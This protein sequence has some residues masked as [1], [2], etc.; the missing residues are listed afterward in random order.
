M[1]RFLTLFLAAFMVFGAFTRAK[2]DEGMWLPLLLNDYNYEE[3]KRLGLKLTPEQIYSINNSSVKDAI[4]SLGGFC[5]AEIVSKE[6]LLFT[7]HHCAYDAIQEHSTVEHNYLKDGFWATSKDKELHVP[8]LTVTFLVKVEDVTERILKI[9][10]G[11]DDDKDRLMQQEMELIKAEATAGTNYRAELKSMFDGNGYY[12]FLYETFNDIRLVGAPPSSIGKFGGDT[13]NWMWPRHTGD[14]SILRVYANQENE[15][16]EFSLDNKPYTP[17][18][19]L[20]VSL[21]GVKDGDFTM[22]MGYPGSTDRYFTSYEVTEQQ[23]VLAPAVIKI[24]G[25][26]LRIM[27]EEMDKDEAVQIKLASNYASLNNTY[28]YFKGNLN[29]LNKF[30][31]AS[32]K[33][34]EEK[35]FEAWVEADKKRQDEYSGVLK[36]IGDLVGGHAEAAEMNFLMNFAGFAPSAVNKGIP[37]WRATLTWERDEEA[38]LSSLSKVLENIDNSFKEYDATTDMRIVEMALK[39]FYELPEEKRP[40][41][42]ESTTWSKRAKGTTIDEQA[43]SYAAWL[44]EKSILVDKERMTKFLNKPKLKKLQKDP[45]VEY[46][47]SVIACYQQNV[48]AAT[49]GYGSELGRLRGIYMKGLMEMNPN[50]QFYPDANS[51]MRL[52]YGTVGNYKSWEG[53]PYDT[54]TW[55]SQIIDKEVPGDDEFDVPAKLHKLLKEKNFGEYAQNGELPICFLHNTDITGGNSGSPV[56][57]GE[58][59][60]IGIAFDG[61]W[62]SMMSDLKFQDEYVRTISVDIRYVLFVID[63]Y[64]GAQNLIDE[65]EIVR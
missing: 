36:Q 16:A 38:T 31:L 56:I 3:M 65:L 22:I 32:E 4:V 57:N 58:G 8:G 41:I 13:D 60:L 5:T 53:K 54:Q 33:A 55:G 20:P 48:L 24:M 44:F 63:K 61:N 51:T 29:S 17:K 11:D 23:E 14:F 1:K 12:M 59:H 50:K 43:K 42:F 45:G 19:V 62:E 47:N 27:K 18:H 34:E 28:K 46:V 49:G 52:T 39:F 21:K 10:N 35:A 25:E 40:D 2:A 6:G 37:F 30:D 7:N 9:K 15:P 26:R 64:A